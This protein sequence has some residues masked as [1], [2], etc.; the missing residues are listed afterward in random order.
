MTI[1]QEREIHVAMVAAEDALSHL[2]K[3]ARLLDTARSWGR[4]DLAA[5]GLLSSLAKHRH[6]QQA[7]QELKEAHR[8][9]RIFSGQLKELDAI[10]AVDVETGDFLGAADLFFGGAFADIAMQARIREAQEKLEEAISRVLAMHRELGK[11]LREG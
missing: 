2:E 1:D 9:L 7:K 6:M 11:M 3:A 10:R 5:G 4:F 8:A